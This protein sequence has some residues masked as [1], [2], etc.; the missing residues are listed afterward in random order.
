V[1]RFKL[2]IAGYV[3]NVYFSTW[4]SK[5][6]STIPTFDGE[7]LEGELENGTKFQGSHISRNPPTVKMTFTGPDARWTID[8]EMITQGFPK[9]VGNRIHGTK[10]G[11]T[12]LSFKDGSEYTF[13]Y[14][15]LSIESA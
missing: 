13:T 1:E 9:G 5:G 7:V 14:P 11:T 15:H 4:E 8:C 12:K 6:K 10:T 2:L 3:G